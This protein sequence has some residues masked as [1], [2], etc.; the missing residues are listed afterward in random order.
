M[1]LLNG[2]SEINISP[3]MHILEPFWLHK[4]FHTKVRSSFSEIDSEQKVDDLINMM[5][6]KEFSGSFWNL[7]EID[8]YKLK[9]DI[10]E[11]DRTTESLFKILIANDAELKGKQRAGAKFPVHF[12]YVSTLTD[13][14]PDCKILHLT[15]DPRAI[16]ASQSKRY[17]SKKKSSLAKSAIRFTTLV[18]ITL[19]YRWAGL[20]HNR[21]KN[22]Q[23]YLL[24]RFEDTVTQPETQLRRIC[25]F[26]RID[27]TPEML[28][29][30]VQDSSFNRD[31]KK[32]FNTQAIDRWKDT[33]TPLSSIFITTLNKRY[34]KQFGY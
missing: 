13:W 25:D 8:K 2:Y 26:L 6:N 12:S 28:H 4:D 1:S 34:V 21:Y 5:Y 31:T 17:A 22:N 27:Y 14:F 20:I 19:S 3:E 18:Y 29:P 11:S 33:I 23:N 9:Q 16:Y 32:G 24:S 30:K 15:R 10:K 7:I